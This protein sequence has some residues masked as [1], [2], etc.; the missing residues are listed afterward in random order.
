MRTLSLPVER[1]LLQ[2]QEC[3]AE[4]QRILR[5][6]EIGHMSETQ[7]AAELYFHAVLWHVCEYLKQYRINLR[8]LQA[9]ADPID[10]ADYGDTPFHRFCFRLLWL[11]PGGRTAKNSPD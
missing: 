10:L 11:L 5:E 3:L 4:A 1:R 2:K 8:S 9:H 6:E 7:I